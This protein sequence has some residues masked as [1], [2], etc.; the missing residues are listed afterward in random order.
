MAAGALIDQAGLKGES[1]AGAVVSH[2]HA[3]YIIVKDPAKTKA[4]DIWAL[5]QKVRTTVRERMGVDLEL[6]IEVWPKP[7]L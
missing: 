3:N 1:V 5:I 4:A 2:K 7:P 6:E